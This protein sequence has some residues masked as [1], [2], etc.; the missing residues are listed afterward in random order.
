MCV[1][2]SLLILQK[3]TQGKAETNENGHIQEVGRNRIEE[4]VGMR[5]F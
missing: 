5:P 4:E 1:H 2:L 3:E